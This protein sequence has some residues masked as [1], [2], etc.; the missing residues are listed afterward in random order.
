M[1]YSGGRQLPLRFSV[2]FTGFFIVAIASGPFAAEKE[3]LGT[4]ASEKAA[5][6][7]LEY[8]AGLQAADGSFGKVPLGKNAAIVGFAGLAFMAGGNTPDKG[9][10]GDNISK[11]AD[12]IKSCQT[13]KGVISASGQAMYEHGFST[14]ALCE[15]YGM[16]KREDLRDSIRKSIDLIVSCQNERGG[17]RY[18]PRIADDDA[19]VTSCQVQ[20]LR[21]ARDVGFIVPQETIQKALQYLKSCNNP[22]GGFSYVPHSGGS[23]TERT[24]ACVL[25]MMALGDYTSPEVDRGCEYLLKTRPNEQSAHFVY[26]LYYCTQVMFQKG[27]DYWKS[28]YPDVRDLLVASQNFDGSWSSKNYGTVYAT[29][30]AALVLQLPAAYLPLFER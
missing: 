4:P 29:A 30:V 6:K 14:L 21:A 12:Y 22:D 7:A 26:G 16:T 20:A 8:L 1:K 13:D 10:Y 17:W 3:Y 9:K 15:L 5:A 27:G 28:W 11:I 23:N 25:S 24:G 2:L 19:S 18:Q